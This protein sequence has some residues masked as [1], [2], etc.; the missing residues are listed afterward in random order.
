MKWPESRWGWGVAALMLLLPAILASQTPAAKAP[1]IKAPAKTGPVRL[2]VKSLSLKGVKAV[3]PKELRL[4]IATDQSHCVSLL[5]APICWIGKTR[6]F[7]TRNYLD[8]A[9]LAR[10]VLRARVFYWKRGY[11]ETAVDTLV[12]QTDEDDV[13]VTFFITEGPPTIVSDITVTQKQKV[14]SDRDIAR[15]VV[16]GKDSPLNLIRLD[17]SRVFLQQALWDKGYADAI[18]DTAMQIDTASKRA[19]VEINL[20]PRW[21]ATV[22]DII[23][24]GNKKIATRT[25]LKSLTLR[26]GSLFKR[27]ELLRSQR[28]LY[29]SNLFRRAAIDIPRQGDSSKVL[30]IR[31]KDASLTTTSSDVPAASTFRVRSAIFSQTSSTENSFFA[32]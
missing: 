29:E 6:Y 32:M 18:V 9:E 28:A 20:D 10:D 8:H 26:P 17:S 25:I 4:S 3:D 23:V 14:L 15:K 7:Y 31:S 11:R 2:E 27:S 21:K 30:I 22:S 24:E 5:L 13:A 19:S 16:L 12:K 1:A